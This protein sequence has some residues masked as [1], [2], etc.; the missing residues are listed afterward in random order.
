MI[1]GSADRPMFYYFNSNKVRLKSLEQI[2]T[3][4]YFLYFNSNK[5]RLK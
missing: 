5:V 4:G 1:G 2:G 3:G